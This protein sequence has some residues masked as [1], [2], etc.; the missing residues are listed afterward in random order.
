MEKLPGQTPQVLNSKFM[1][2]DKAQDWYENL[3]AIVYHVKER[4]NAACVEGN[5]PY[6]IEKGATDLFE[7]FLK[8]RTHLIFGLDCNGFGCVFRTYVWAP[9]SKRSWQWRNGETQDLKPS[10][11]SF[12]TDKTP[13]DARVYQ[14]IRDGKYE[15]VISIDPGVNV[16]CDVSK[17][18][19]RPDGSY[20]LDPQHVR[21]TAKEMNDYTVFSKKISKIL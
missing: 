10:L 16:I 2:F 3:M 5:N 12:V 9:L 13:L 1:T 19:K 8:K 21:L 7:A 20:Q 18:S 17:Y 15:T 11:P 6:Q 14:N 4:K